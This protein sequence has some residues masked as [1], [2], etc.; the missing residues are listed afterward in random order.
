MAEAVPDQWKFDTV[1]VDEGQDFEPIWA[2]ML[3]LFLQ[4]PH[5]VLC[6]EDPD[7][8]LRD[9]R[10]VVRPASWATARR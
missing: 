2:D 7:Q 1:I 6:L 4:G 9:Q 10:P 5:D 3:G 8:N